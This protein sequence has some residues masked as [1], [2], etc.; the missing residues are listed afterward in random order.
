MMLLN[1]IL[2]KTKN[3]ARGI[4]IT[5]NIAVVTAASLKVSAIVLKNSDSMMTSQ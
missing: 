4:A 1:R 5:N 2:E 3:D